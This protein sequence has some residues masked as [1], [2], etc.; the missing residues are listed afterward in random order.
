MA[1]GGYDNTNTGMIYDNDRKKEE[2]HPDVKGF[3][4]VEGREYWVSGWER[5]GKNGK[6]EG[7]EFI[8][9]AIEPKDDDRGGQRD[10]RR[11]RDRGDDSR[12]NRRDDRG[13]DR[14]GSRDDDRGRRSNR[15]DERPRR[16]EGDSPSRGKK[17]DFDDDIPF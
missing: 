10:T 7:K 3:I 13:D 9:L 15:D 1:S 11:S 6:W 14:R 5:V 17:D 8:S 16:S 12:D 2:N 4:N